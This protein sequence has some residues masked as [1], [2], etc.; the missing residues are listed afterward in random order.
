MGT[1]SASFDGD[2]NNQ[3][4]P[5]ERSPRS[6]ERKQIGET[7]PSSDL[8]PLQPLIEKSMEAFLQSLDSWNKVLEDQVKEMG[9]S[10]KTIHTF[11]GD[12][13]KQGTRANK[14]HESATKRRMDGN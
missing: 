8:Q 4:T 13:A 7:P 10:F 12:L 1:P 9:N 11:A 2:D 14:A 5:D 3:P 6:E